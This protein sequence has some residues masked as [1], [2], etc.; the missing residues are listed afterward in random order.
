MKAGLM[1]IAD[2]FV[3]N[4]SDRAGAEQAVMSIRTVLGFKPHS[5]G[6]APGVLQ[7]VAS[8]GKGIDLIAAQIDRHREYQEKA[9][10]LRSKRVGRIS[11]RIRELVGERVPREERRTR[12]PEAIHPVRRGRGADQDLPRL[13]VVNRTKS[14]IF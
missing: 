13:S 1:E 8:E 7:A 9:D 3:V 10:V 5:E 14:R 2:F 12:V 4:K 11:E 6:W